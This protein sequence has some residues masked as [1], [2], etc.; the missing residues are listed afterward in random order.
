[1]LN[2][3]EKYIDMPLKLR[4]STLGLRGKQ[5]A[6]KRFQSDAVQGK[7][8]EEYLIVLLLGTDTV[9]EWEET[10]KHVERLKVCSGLPTCERPL[11]H[12]PWSYL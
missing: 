7:K 6:G 3:K 8:L 9:Y 2:R 4:D 11:K 10:A 5:D 1:M 12:I